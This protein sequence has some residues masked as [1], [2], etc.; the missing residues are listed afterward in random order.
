M[1]RIAI[2]AA[3]SLFALAVAGTIHAQ[4]KP[5]LD[6]PEQDKPAPEQPLELRFAHS[7]AANHPLHRAIEAWALSINKA[8]NG[9]ISIRIFPAQQLGLAFDHY[10]MA[11]DGA[12]DIAQVSPGYEP[13]RFP[14]MGLTEIPLIIANAKEGSAALDAWYRKYADREMKEVKYCIAFAHGPATFHT[15]GKRLAVP[16][17][18]KNTKIRPAN[19]T[20]SR[21]VTQLGGSNVPAPAADARDLLATG[22]AEGVTLPWGTAVSLGIDRV[23][24]FHLDLPLYV[25]AHAV[26]MTKA[27]YDA[28]SPAQRKVIDDHCTPE[29]A[30]TIAAPWAAME[31]S[32]RDRIRAQAGK[33]VYAITPAQL[34]EWRK[35]VQPLRKDWDDQVRRAGGSPAAIYRD[36]QDELRKRNS[37]Y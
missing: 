32:G 21:L 37:L 7:E 26:V 22:V 13:G 11:R 25:T 30:E 29:W 3:A 18:L 4:N 10:N 23:T 17:D 12:A 27:K 6:K 35:A 2:H 36:L 34:A 20:V 15:V 9:T 1:K 28:L 14:V 31:A 5:A 33:D 16:A 8:S 24:R 19:A